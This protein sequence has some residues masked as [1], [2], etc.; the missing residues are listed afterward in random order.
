MQWRKWTFAGLQAL[1]ATQQI[2]KILQ[3]NNIFDYVKHM[4]KFPGFQE[5]FEITDT[6]FCS[7]ESV[8]A[9]KMKSIVQNRLFH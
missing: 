7:E 6:I 8:N 1:Q 5:A 9:N 4:N 2:K 3:V